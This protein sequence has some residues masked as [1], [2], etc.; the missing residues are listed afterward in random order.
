MS[1]LDDKSE[2]IVSI[3]NDIGLQVEKAMA[4]DVKINELALDNFVSNYDETLNS[5]QTDNA[6]KMLTGVGT[7]TY[8][9]IYDVFETNP[10]T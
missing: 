3:L 10:E 8:K 7:V 9:I 6:Q 4:T 5:A 1:E 2:K